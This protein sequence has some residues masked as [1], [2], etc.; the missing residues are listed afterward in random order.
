MDE[1]VPNPTES[2]ILPTW[3]LIFRDKYSNEIHDS[4][5]TEKLNVSSFL[6]SVKIR[7]CVT[8]SSYTKLINVCQDENEDD[9]AWN[10]AA[11]TQRM[12]T[13]LF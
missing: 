12:G 2:K 8:D 10:P 1:K 6:G 3:K 13:S 7:L 9:G 5:I 4:E 11:D